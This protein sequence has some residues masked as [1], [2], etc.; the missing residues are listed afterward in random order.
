MD[1]AELV[2]RL[3]HP[4]QV[5]PGPLRKVALNDHVWVQYVP[6]TETFPPSTVHNRNSG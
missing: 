6:G 1:V 4:A 5:L 3:P 2:W